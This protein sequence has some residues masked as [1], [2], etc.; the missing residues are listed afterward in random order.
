MA[1]P[2]TNC[3]L[4]AFR[5]KELFWTK[6]QNCWA[7]PNIFLNSVLGPFEHVQN[8]NP[9]Q[10]SAVFNE[11]TDPFL[12]TVHSAPEGCQSQN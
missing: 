2:K 12:P 11:A 10:E 8:E 3:D 7:T 5:V 6:K 4:R 9:S 1:Q